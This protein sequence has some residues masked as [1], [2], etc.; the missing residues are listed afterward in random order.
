MAISED[1]D[2]TDFPTRYVLG[3]DYQLTQAVDL[4]AEYE[5]ASGKGIDATM[6]RVGVRTRPWSRAEASTYLTNE[7]T[8]FGPR[9][10]AN[11]GLI[12]GFQISERWSGDVGLDQSNTLLDEDARV[13]DSDR[14]LVS[15]S[16]NEDFLAIHA[17]AMYS[18]EYWSANSR[19]EHRNSDSEERSTL[20]IGW[21]REPMVGHGMSAGVGYMQSENINGNELTRADFKLGWAYRKADSKWSFLDRVDLIF[22]RA[23]NGAEELE[24]WRVINNFNANR[25]FSAAMQMS[26]QYAFKYVSNEFDDDAYSG[27]TDLIGFDLR[28]GM[29]QRWDMGIN[30]SIYHSYNSKVIDYGL[31]ADVGF[32]VRDNMWLTLGY[33]IA[34]FYDSD[35][36]QARYTAQGPY[37]RFSIKADQQTLK[38]IAGRR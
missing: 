12:Q 25:R 19:I 6:T 35:F 17:G 13:F 7:V 1:A 31:G 24:S 21:Y 27:Y 8:E 10:F 26:L 32:N 29:R 9:L 20:L 23:I 18:A 30:T 36:S 14:E 11:V 4:V 28:R 15:G 5:K 16:L 38:S 3:A 37:L 2:N 33:N 22:D 34:G